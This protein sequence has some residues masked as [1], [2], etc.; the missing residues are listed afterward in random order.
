M[1]SYTAGLKACTTTADLARP[2]QAWT[3]VVRTFR[4]AGTGVDS[5]GATRRSAR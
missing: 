1:T 2:R 4:S 3:V 5:R